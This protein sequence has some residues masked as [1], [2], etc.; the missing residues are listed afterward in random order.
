MTSYFMGKDMFNEVLENEMARLGHRFDVRAFT[1]VILNAG[2]V[3]IDMI[4][5]LLASATR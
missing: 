1:D 2:A 4:P 3:P 5:S